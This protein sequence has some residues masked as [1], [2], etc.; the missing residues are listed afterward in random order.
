V[1]LKERMNCHRDQLWHSHYNERTKKLHT[2][3]AASSE[4]IKMKSLK[5]RKNIFNYIFQSRRDV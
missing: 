5:G 3:A 4:S 1:E 2:A